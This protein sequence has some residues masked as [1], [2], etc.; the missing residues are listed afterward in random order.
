MQILGTIGCVIRVSEPK[1]EMPI[2]GLSSSN[3]KTSCRRRTKVL[4]SEA[5]GNAVSAPKF[6]L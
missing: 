6:K 4:N 3:S 2:G 1:A 5:L